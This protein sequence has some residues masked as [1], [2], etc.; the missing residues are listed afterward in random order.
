M[1]KNKNVR[2]NV[3]NRLF[4]CSFTVS[5]EFCSKSQNQNS[6]PFTKPNKILKMFL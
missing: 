4:F 6:E 2:K 1:S 5:S 3:Q